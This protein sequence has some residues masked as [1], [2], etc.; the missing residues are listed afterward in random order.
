MIN[1]D[2]DQT[3]RHTIPRWLSIQ[4]AI[5]GG[6]FSSFSPKSK[7][8]YVRILDEYASN[9]LRTEFEAR[10][11]A[12]LRTKDWYDAEE[13]IALA[14]VVGATD[15]AVAMEAAETLVTGE[16]SNDG[17][18]EFAKRFLNGGIQ[19]ER[20][21][22]PIAEAEVRVEIAKRKR[23]LALNPRDALRLTETALLH[24][25]LGQLRASERLIRRALMLTPDDRYVLRAAT[26]FFVHLGE[27]EKAIDVLGR[28]ARTRE[29][30]WLNSALLATEAASGR[31]SRS[32]RRANS[33]LSD[34]KFSPRDLSE[35]AAQIGTMEIA[36]GARRR[37]VKLLRLGAASPTENA[38][39][40]IAWVGNHS[41]AF[42]PEDLLSDISISHEASARSAYANGSWD[43]AL[44]ESIAWQEIER[45]SARP[46]VFGTFVASVTGKSLDRALAL[47]DAALVANPG[48]AMLLN[49]IAV[50]LAYSGNLPGAENTLEKAR[51]HARDRMP[52]HIATAGL[53]AFR[54]GDFVTGCALYQQTIELATELGHFEE[55]LRAYCFYAREL[56]RF[57]AG[58]ANQVIAHIDRMRSSVEK[59]VRNVSR[60]VDFIRSEI[61]L[62]APLST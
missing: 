9:F 27:P 20:V 7:G 33:L 47:A 26:R 3:A 6:H 28:S 53:I 42:E 31:Q 52:S 54:R 62:N 36:A 17:V 5:R 56:V 18:R 12:W 10:R 44:Q 37:A 11:S 14:V 32:W 13:F 40:Q 41:R 35:L 1:P 21:T 49:N 45:F 2:D 58:F 22:L 59:K 16:A 39:A 48:N 50:L 30:P 4:E 57:D 61:A 60:D 23:M 46:A 51:I 43:D 15:D 19:P 25:N 24:A 8:D 29:D 34:A 38:V 55:A